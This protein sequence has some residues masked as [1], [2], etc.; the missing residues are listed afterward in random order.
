MA[1]R[2]RMAEILPPTQRWR[3]AWRSTRQESVKRHSVNRA[4]GS[5]VDRSIID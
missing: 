3:R 4:A 2:T 1:S 5:D